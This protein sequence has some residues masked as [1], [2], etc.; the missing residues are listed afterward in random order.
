M[1]ASVDPR[2][3]FT[4]AAADYVRY[5]PGYPPEAIDWI[6][7]TASVATGARIVDLGC[8]T[9]I[10]TRLFAERG[11]DLIGVDPNEEMLGYAR[12]EGGATYVRGESVATGLPD[13]SVDLVVSAQAFHWFDVAPTL[14]EL[15]RIL[16]PSGRATAFW[17]IRT[18]SPTMDAYDQLL[19]EHSSEYEPH[20]RD[21]SR[22]PLRSADG[23]VDPREAE[24]PWVERL[25]WEK[26]WGRVRSSSYIVH[27]V[28]S[29][30]KRAALEDAL[31]RF[32]TDHARDGTLS[33]Q[34]RTEIISFR[35]AA[36]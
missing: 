5:R 17:N 29:D 15:G 4:A 11:H 9:G 2:E 25:G 31:R 22:I 27:G 13:A 34:A 30:D 3:R 21:D 28:A 10:A 7:A 33:W 32:F 12:R 26:L 8:G 20:V 36:S 14:V 16:R 24:F 6:L 23:V 35:V 18:S 19:V 1:T